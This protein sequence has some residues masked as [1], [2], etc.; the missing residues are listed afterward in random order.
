MKRL[1]NTILLTLVLLLTNNAFAQN[2]SI[3]DLPTETRK[4]GFKKENIGLQMGGNYKENTNTKQIDDYFSKNGIFDG[5]QKF[6]NMLLSILFAP[7]EFGVSYNL[8]KRNTIY[9]NF[10]VFTDLFDSR[11]IDLF[12]ISEPDTE[13]ELSSAGVVMELYNSFSLLYQVQNNSGWKINAAAGLNFILGEQIFTVEYPYYPQQSLNNFEM[14]NV[15]QSGFNFSVGALFGLEL[16]YQINRKYALYCMN[17][18]S[19]FSNKKLNAFEIN[20]NPYAAP[21]KFDDKAFLNKNYSFS[22]GLKYRFD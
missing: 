10:I 11:G 13:V 14:K 5:A 7:V 2:D 15:N 20:D 17:K 18:M 3:A 1:R 6:N 21:K 8:N 4:R 12:G 9:T 22:F 19:Y 16:E